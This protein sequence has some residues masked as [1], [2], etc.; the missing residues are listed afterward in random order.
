M[1]NFLGPVMSNFF[2]PFNVELFRTLWYRTFDG[3]IISSILGLYHVG[4]LMTQWCRAFYD[5]MMSSFLG[6]YD[7]ELFRTFWCL[8]LP[9]QCTISIIYNYEWCKSNSVITQSPA[10]FF[11]VDLD[12]LSF[13]KDTGF[14]W[15]SSTLSPYTCMIRGQ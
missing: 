10:W 8:R 12:Y 11:A 3:P 9:E 5:L 14:R 6:L 2:G 7:V 1:S 4:L 13:R 15:K